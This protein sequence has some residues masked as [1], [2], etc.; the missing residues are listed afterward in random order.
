MD[1]YTSIEDFLDKN[2]H[3][4]SKASVFKDGILFPF[5]YKLSEKSDGIVF[6]FPGAFNRNNPM[7][8]FQ[9]SSF[10][11]S[12]EFSCISFFDPTLFLTDDDKFT[13]AWFVGDNDNWYINHLTHIVKKIISD[14]NI[15]NSKVIFFGSSAGGIPSIHLAS[16]FVDSHAYCCNIQTNILSHYPSYLNRLIK[17]CFG[18]H[19][20]LGDVKNKISERLD[21]TSLDASFSL[22]IVQN[23]SDTF[24][25][26]NHFLP[27]MKSLKLS[28]HISYES[29]IYED[30][31]IGHNPLPKQKEIE[32]INQIALTGTFNSCFDEGNFKTNTE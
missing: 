11:P 2:K 5:E 9:R 12:L 30:K 31:T 1:I 23:K 21:I 10:F 24:H 3:G 4:A 13:R 7:P 20:E 8:K 26:Q 14:K 18:K 32:I 27:Y 6:F 17:T 25:Y 19:T 15:N 28:Q 29:I 22:H 16:R